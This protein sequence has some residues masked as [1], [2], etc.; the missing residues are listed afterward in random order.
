MDAGTMMLIGTGVQAG[1]KIAAGQ[2]ARAAGKYNAAALNAQATQEVAAAERTA[3]ERRHETERVISKQIAGAAASGAG[4]GPSLLDIIGDTAQRGEY[5]AQADMYGGEEKARAL[6]NK[7]NIA[8]YEG[9]SA[10][11]GSLLE[12]VGSL[13]L[14]LGRYSNTY[15]SGSM[16]SS[17]PSGPRK[18]NPYR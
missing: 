11:A 7:A 12:G 3:A 5:R 13:A 9:N 2:S 17:I 16:L 14:G 10:Y 15:G 18:V 8:R 4:F 1:A 6:K